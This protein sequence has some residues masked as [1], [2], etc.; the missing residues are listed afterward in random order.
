MF[1]LYSWVF[2]IG[3]SDCVG[4]KSVD[5]QLAQHTHAPTVAECQEKSRELG[6]NLV[7]FVQRHKDNAEARTWSANLRKLSK[8]S[9]TVT[10]TEVECRWR[11]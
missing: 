8:T 1:Y 9:G 6:K 4:W 2:C 10:V 3:L 7:S 11:P 5:E